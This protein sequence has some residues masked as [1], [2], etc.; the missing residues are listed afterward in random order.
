MRLHPSP[1]SLYFF[2]KR[3]LSLLWLIAKKHPDLS[4]R[5]DPYWRIDMFQRN[6]EI[7]ATEL[8]VVAM[9]VLTSIS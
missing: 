1:N 2:Q 7:A 8:H 6:Q 4:A 9:I 3:I 5:L